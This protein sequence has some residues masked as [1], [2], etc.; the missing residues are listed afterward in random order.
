M[1]NLF[2][3]CN[4]PIKPFLIL[5]LNI[6]KNTFNEIDL[7]VEKYIHLESNSQC[8]YEASFYE[9]FGLLFWKSNFEICSRKC[10]PFTLHF[11]KSDCQT[12]EELRCASNLAHNLLLD[13]IKTEACPKSCSYIQYSGKML[14]KYERVTNEVHLFKIVYQSFWF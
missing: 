12:V 10:I 11:M 8:Q 2:T 5:E 1:F 9:C 13:I 4:L 6:D 3:V 14:Y 7:K